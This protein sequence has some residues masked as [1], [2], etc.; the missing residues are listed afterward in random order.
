MHKSGKQWRTLVAIGLVLFALAN[1]QSSLAAKH[2][3][4]RV[5]RILV[6][7][8]SL[9]AGLM[10]KP[11]ETWPMRLVDKLRDAGLEFVVINASRSGDTTNGGLDRLAAQLKRPIDI[12]IVELGINDAW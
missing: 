11:S 5:K 2:D 10:L 9:S 8:D 1:A 3:S 7:G 12:F 6:L 4:T